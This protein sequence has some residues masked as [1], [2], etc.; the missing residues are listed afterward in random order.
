MYLCT[1]HVAVF[2][3][4]PTLPRPNRVTDCEREPTGR[5]DD[6]STAPGPAQ[7]NDNDEQRFGPPAP[8][9]F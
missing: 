8:R 5:P 2:G 3:E 4:D 7:K 1:G 9:P 6:A